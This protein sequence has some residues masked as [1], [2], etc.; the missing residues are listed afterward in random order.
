MRR[1]TARL[2]FPV[3]ALM[4][5]VLLA[6]CSEDG[7]DAGRLEVDG[8][9]EVAREGGDYEPAGDGTLRAGDRVRV[10]TGTA[11]L[12]LGDDRTVELRDGSEVELAARA[13]VDAGVVPS[14]LAGDLLVTSPASP[15]EVVA[16]DI[17]V[18]VP[19]GSA[20]L[21]RGLVTVVASYAGR[22][23]AGSPGR[24]IDIPALRQ[25]SVPAAGLL[26]FRPSPL[27][28]QPSDS[29]DQRML[30]DAIDLGE[31]L[32]RQSR[33]FTAQ[34][35]T[36]E[37]RTPGFY[38]Q[39]LP[40]LDGEPAF[41]TAM[42]GPTR[43]PGEALV[44]LA[45]TVEGKRGSFEERVRQVFEFHDEGAAW[46][47]VALD[48]GVSS[49]PLLN[50]VETAISR[51]PALAAEGGSPPSRAPV[52]T[53]PSTRAPGSTTPRASTPST[54]RSTPTTTPT[55]NGQPATP[56]SVNVEQLVKDLLGTVEDVLGG[57]VRGILGQ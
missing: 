37:G 7:D 45:I 39:L 14:L 57:L 5:A 34:R 17:E 30:G 3:T 49:T 32:A 40:A 28:Y 2:V 27:V 24:S 46:G 33:G 23:T 31:K 25:V 55:D 53:T 42:L 4:A 6:G 16:G 11:V 51:G 26:P 1:G 47:L 12:R 9:A 13:T 35:G 50:G 44:G 43:D 8:T 38:R 56:P 21:S 36:G 52:T 20:R 29:W 18:S 48:Q 10:V 15:L 19:G 54:I 41:D 22:L